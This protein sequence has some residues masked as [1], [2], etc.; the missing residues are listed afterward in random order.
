MEFGLWVRVYG[1]FF[2]LYCFF[3]VAMALKNNN[4][5]DSS[6]FTYCIK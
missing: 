6:K 2:L 1:L 5:P 3:A 4:E